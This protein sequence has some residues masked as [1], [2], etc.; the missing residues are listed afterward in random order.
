MPWGK[1]QPHPCGLKGR[2]TLHALP[3]LARTEALSDVGGHLRKSS[4]DWLRNRGPQT[5][6]Q[7][8]RGLSGRTALSISPPRASAYGLGPGLRSPGPLGRM[9]RVLA[10]ERCTRRGAALL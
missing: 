2:E 3:R 8:S 7:Q 4:N 1:R 9:R 6:G 10:C 5:P